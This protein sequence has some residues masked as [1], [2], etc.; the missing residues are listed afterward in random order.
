MIRRV[1]T[2]FIGFITPVIPIDFWPFLRAVTPGINGRA[3][4]ELKSK[5]EP[6]LGMTLVQQQLTVSPPKN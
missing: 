3:H 1:T 5:S 2:P 6:A 4:L